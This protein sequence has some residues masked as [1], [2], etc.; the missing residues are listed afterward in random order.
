ME[1]DD[2]TGPRFG[3]VD[4]DWF[5]A[6]GH[7]GTRIHKTARIGYYATVKDNARVGQYC[8]VLDLAVIRGN[9]AMCSTEGQGKGPLLTDSCRVEGMAVISG[10]CH[11][12]GDALVLGTSRV[13]DSAIVK[14]NAI[15]KNS[16]VSDT[17]KV[18]EN[19]QLCEASS[20]R[21]S[22]VVEG[23]AILL[24][25]SA[26]GNSRI[27]G[28]ATMT[29]STAKDRAILDGQAMANSTEISGWLHGVAPV[30]FGI[31]RWSIH[32]I[33]C[34]TFSIG[35]Q[36]HNVRSWLAPSDPAIPWFDYLNPAEKDAVQTTLR[37]I[38]AETK[39]SNTWSPLLLN[40]EV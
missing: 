26:Y 18:H 6:V 3:R 1:L 22:A 2:L 24:L 9:A 15:V 37:A 4:D 29:S 10:T 5:Y 23:N 35:C 38:V 14:G 20:V 32:M 21:G 17:A 11:V 39:R 19:A 34:D 7:P 8:S 16:F 27:R 36:T 40:D 28:R 13:G 25:S 31:T 30:V 12:G 33:S